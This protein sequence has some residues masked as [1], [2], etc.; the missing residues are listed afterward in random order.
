M[1]SA[2]DTVGIIH[3]GRLVVVDERQA[4]LDRYA[5]PAVEVEFEASRD[6]KQAW[7]RQVA[8]QP[9]VTGVAEHEQTIR[10]RL[11]GSTHARMEIARLALGTGLPVTRFAIARPTLEDVFL[12]LVGDE[13]NQAS[14]ERG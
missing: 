4:L 9:F 13:A 2:C 12:G 11:D 5:V 6:Q 7:R 8:A 10:I 3:Q 1:S 14:T